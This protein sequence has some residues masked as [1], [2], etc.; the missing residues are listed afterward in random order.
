MATKIWP[1]ALFPL[2]LR[3]RRWAEIAWA[4]G[5]ISVTSLAAV[6]WLGPEVIDD[7]VSAL[8]TTVPV[9]PGNPVLWVTWFREHTEWWPR[10]GAPIL[11]ALLRLIPARGLPGIGLGIVA[12]VTL[13]PN[14]WGH[15]LPVLVFGVGLIIMA[16]LRTSGDEM[17]RRPGPAPEV[18]IESARMV[19]LPRPSVIRRNAR[20]KGALERSS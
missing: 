5:T 20:D 4:A 2:L 3:E 16:R 18:V 14:I 8:R 10:W 17:L 13:V 7:M 15:Y 9:L 6:A 1:V 12:G 11:A 19:R